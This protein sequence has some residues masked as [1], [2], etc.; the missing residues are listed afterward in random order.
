MATK[1]KA[2]KVAMVERLTEAFKNATSTV[3]VHFRG[4]TVGDETA[5]RKSLRETGVK[6][7]VVRKTLI[8]RALQAAGLGEL[9]MDGEVA[10]VHGGEDASVA[11]RSIHTF[12]KSF[13]AEK[14]AIVGGVFGGMVKNALEMQAIATIPSMPVLRGMFANVIN[15]PRARFAIALSEVAK[16]KQEA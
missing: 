14:L 3:F 9:S 7:V 11:S 10:V 12:V 5:M 1:T 6:Y 15:S 16:S 13:G 2:D 4:M 8:A